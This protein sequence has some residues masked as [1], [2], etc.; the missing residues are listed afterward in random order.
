MTTTQPTNTLKPLSDCMCLC[1]ANAAADYDPSAS[2][3]TFITRTVLVHLDDTSADIRVRLLSPQLS[4]ALLCF[5]LLSC[6]FVARP[7]LWLCSKKSH[8]TIRQYYCK[9]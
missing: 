9:K 7:E 6:L 4:F 8:P 3:F 1:V 5:A 2:Q